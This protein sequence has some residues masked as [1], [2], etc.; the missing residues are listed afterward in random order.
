MNKTGMLF[1]VM[2]TIGTRMVVL[3]GAFLVSVILARLLGPEGKGIITAVLVIPTLVVTIADLGI[4]QASAYFIGTKAYRY[5]DI[6]SSL[7]FLWMM[8][9]L[10]SIAV[11]SVILA[12]QYG[13]KYDWKI[14]AA[15][16]MTIPVNLGIQYLRGIMQ[17]RGRIGS[18][19]KVEIIKTF[20]NFTILLLLV[21]LFGMGVL[22]AALT[23]LLMALFTLGYSIKLLIGEVKIKLRYIHPLPLQLIRK[24]F[25]FAFALFI[26]QMNYRVDIVIL[27]YFTNIS[28]VGI[29]S[30]GTN[31]SEL[32]WQLPA[33]VGLILFS[34]SANSDSAQAAVESTARLIRMVIPFLIVFGL[35][36]WLLAPL[37]IGLLYGADFA[38]SGIVIRYLLPGILVMVIFK[39]IH[40]DLSGR[41]APLVSL[42]VS[43]IALAVNLVLNLLLIPRMGAI[44]S[45]IASSVSYSIAG[46]SFVWIY[47]RRESIRVRDVLVLNREDWELIKQ[48]LAIRRFGI[49]KIS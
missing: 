39:L 15:C 6:V 38:A 26:I 9:S 24:G 3:F 8:T 27:E 14:L 43:L 48:K 5:E 30:V 10:I 31:L 7:I 36:F 19:N 33:A 42:N 12:L 41:G 35:F 17:G 18:I 49:N 32:I 21:W 40:S 28:E 47:A 25:S 1:Q 16:I 29:Y 34:R 13:G 2:T 23:Q 45:A 22:G 11:V 4:R 37:L 46:L 20:L 44:G